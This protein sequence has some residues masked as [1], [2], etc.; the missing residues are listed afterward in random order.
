MNGSK[1][2]LLVG[3]GNLGSRYLEGLFKI[4]KFNCRIDVIENSSEAF[5]FGLTRAR[6]SIDQ[7]D[8][9]HAVRH[10]TFAG[11]ESSYDIAIIATPSGPRAELVGDLMLSTQ[12]GSWIL[13]KV[14]SNSISGLRL[15][16]SN[17]SSADRVWVNT[18][19]RFSSF[20]RIMK[21]EI[22]IVDP[23]SM[24]INCGQFDLG[25]N[26][27]HFLDLLSWLNN[28]ELVD[29][30][31]MIDGGWY[32]AKR[33]GYKEFK[34]EVRGYYANGAYLS[35]KNTDIS[36]N[37]MLIEYDVRGRR[38]R[39]DENNGFKLTGENF[40]GRVEYQSEITAP[41]VERI[42]SFTM[43]DELPTLNESL[44]QHF[45]FFGDLSKSYSLVS[46]NDDEVPIT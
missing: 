34:G 42:L 33:A 14:L 46:F 29:V 21:R 2:I 22:G 45:L 35:I 20:Y 3:L 17:L 27:I 31:T 44:Q 4:R 6:S 12:V 30:K 25:C 37:E 28:S 40:G 18:P 10:V 24:S 36:Q 19:R 13:E 16:S 26:S 5:E 9:Q 1:N 39:L 8:S 11:L 41:L 43:T 23:V 38:F 15:I 32:A 7:I